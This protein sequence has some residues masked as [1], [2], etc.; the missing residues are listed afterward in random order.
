[1][2]SRAPRFNR[3]SVEHA[4]KAKRAEPFAG[5]FDG[6]R[7]TQLDIRIAP[8][9]VENR[10][11][12]PS[13]AGPV[14]RLRTGHANRAVVGSEPMPNLWRSLDSSAF[15]AKPRHSVAADS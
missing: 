12:Y 1:M 5:L 6:V 3:L 11:N 15:C 10:A 7:P 14:Q 13:V 9:R 2:T 4:P 8:L